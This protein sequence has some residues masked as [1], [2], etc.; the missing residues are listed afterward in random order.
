MPWQPRGSGGSAH[1]YLHKTVAVLMREFVARI[2][3]VNAMMVQFPP[4]FNTAQ[5]QEDE[6]KDF[7][8]FGVPLPWKVEMV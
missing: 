4:K 6:M 1:H 3:D 8:E 7:L 5:I 2:N